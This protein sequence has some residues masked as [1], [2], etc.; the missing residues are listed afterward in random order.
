[1]VA[2]ITIHPLLMAVIFAAFMVIGL[3]EY[4][5]LATIATGHSVDLITGII[6]GLFQF[7]ILF[8][9]FHL[10]LPSDYLA[11]LLIGP[12]YTM[13][14]ALFRK[15]SEPFHHAGIIL[16]GLIYVGLP[17]ALVTGLAYSPYYPGFDHHLLLFIL[18][19][20][21]VY[22]SGAYL[23]GKLIGRHPMFKRISPKKT[24]EGVTGGV[25]FSM[26][27][28]W[29]MISLHPTIPS[30]HQWI[31]TVV[32]IIS[33]TYGDLMES[34]FKRITGQKDSGKIMPGH[35]G[36]LDR[37]DSLLFVVPAVF[38]TIMILHLP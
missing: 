16:L 5:K 11:L 19:I 38:V 20:I 33:G 36:I 22:D 28:T 17:L 9:Y 12:L 15:G 13:L 34:W 21:W 4:T 25:I 1:M 14:S 24:W 30:W 2:G 37:L 18:V 35:G 29:L 6:A 27:A 26:L 8:L 10:T 3:I 23:T 7:L 32:I 31:L